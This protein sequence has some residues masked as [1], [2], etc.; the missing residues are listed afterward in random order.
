MD[1]QSTSDYDDDVPVRFTIPQPSIDEY[2][3]WSEE[4]Q[5]WTTP[6]EGDPQFYHPLWW[7][8]HRE[9]MKN[10]SLEERRTF[11]ISVQERMVAGSRGVPPSRHK[12]AGGE[13]RDLF[14]NLSDDGNADTQ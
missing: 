9:K 11:I 5:G 6:E 13:P 8:S 1:Q 12:P 3:V 10:L 14:S 2:M 4:V 7:P